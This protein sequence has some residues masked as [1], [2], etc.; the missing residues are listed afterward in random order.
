MHD[1]D[2]MA[3]FCK[4][5]HKDLEVVQGCELLRV[6][7]DQAVLCPEEARSVDLARVLEIL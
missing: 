6:L 1:L 3:L 7:L 2:Q 5:F 4:G